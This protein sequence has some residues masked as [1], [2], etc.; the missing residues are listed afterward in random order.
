MDCGAFCRISRIFL[1]PPTRPRFFI[2]HSFPNLVGHV[3]CEVGKQCL[4]IRERHRVPREA[5]A[6]EAVDWQIDRPPQWRY[7]ANAVVAGQQYGM[8]SPR[9]GTLASHGPNALHSSRVENADS[10][11]LGLPLHPHRAAFNCK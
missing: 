7:C 1:F 6:G 11:M 10:D 8:G 3:L 2:I 4:F 5:D 9:T